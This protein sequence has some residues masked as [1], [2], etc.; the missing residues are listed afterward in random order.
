MAQHHE[1]TDHKHGTM[2]IAEQERTYN[3]FLK[4][5]T[6]GTIACLAVVIF[7]ALANA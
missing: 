6:W 3:G 7:L 5:L 1:V 2:N 4:F